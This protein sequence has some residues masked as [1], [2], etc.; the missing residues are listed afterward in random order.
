MT[1]WFV[2]SSF[3]QNGGQITLYLRRDFLSEK[4]DILKDAP[5]LCQKSATIPDSISFAKYKKSMQ[6]TE[7]L[8]ASIQLRDHTTREGWMVIYLA[9]NRDEQMVVN[10]G[11]H[12]F[13]I[14]SSGSGTYDRPYDILAIQVGT[15]SSMLTIRACQ[16]LATTLYI[17][18]GSKIY[19]I[20]YFPYVSG[21]RYTDDINIYDSS[22]TIVALALWVSY[23][24]F[25]LSVTI[26]DSRI[27][28]SASL[29]NLEQRKWTEEHK[30]RLCAPNYSAYYEYNPAMADTSQFEIECVLLPGNPYLRVVPFTTSTDN[31][32]YGNSRLSGSGLYCKSDFSFSKI[33]SAWT[34]YV[35]QNRNY[36]AIFNRQIQSLDLKNSYQDQLANQQLAEDIIGTVTGTA[37]S[38]LTGAVAGTML[39]PGV[40]TAVGAIAG[41]VASATAGVTDTV[42]NNQNRQTEKAIRDDARQASIDQFQYQIGNIQ[43]QPYSLTSVDAFT[44]TTRIYPCIE[45]YECTEQEKTNLDESIKYNG[46]DINLIAKLSDFESGFVKGSIL[47]FPKYAPAYVPPAANYANLDINDKQARAINA[48]LQYGV[49]I[50]EV[51]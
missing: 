42:I 23:S 44:P 4:W 37:S 17:S 28:P 2:M 31:Q 45:V 39:M 34:E 29:S 7:S 22:E 33:D 26:D 35:I 9:K 38:A 50:K 20:Q 27:R 13:T 36:E 14:P 49:Y 41:G 21:E 48:E 25:S 16:S 30:I 46:L 51:S 6:M 3:K 10:D 43:A 11:T 15:A 18:F 47:Q 40:G 5:F 1:Y 12:H 32:F 8:K 24:Q 19:D